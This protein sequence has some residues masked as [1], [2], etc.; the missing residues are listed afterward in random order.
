[1]VHPGG[2]MHRLSPVSG[3]RRRRK[4]HGDASRRVGSAAIACE[5]IQVRPG[6]N[7][8]RPFPRQ[9][10]SKEYGGGPF[11]MAQ[12]HGKESSVNA[13]NFYSPQEAVPESMCRGGFTCSTTNKSLSKNPRYS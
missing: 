6:T 3:I 12:A 7:A 11:R 8:C 9:L 10:W 13:P 1:M 4:V 5:S 2:W